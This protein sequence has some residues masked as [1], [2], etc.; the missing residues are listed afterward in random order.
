MILTP[1][2]VEKALTS[3]S[4][5]ERNLANALKAACERLARVE[6]C[7]TCRGEEGWPHPVTGKWKPCPDCLA[8]GLAHRIWHDAC[9]SLSE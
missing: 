8:T 2:Q 4:L 5:A 7:P 3:P 9:R 6:K 1:E